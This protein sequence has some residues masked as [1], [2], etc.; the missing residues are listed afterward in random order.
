MFYQGKVMLRISWASGI[1][2]L[3][4]WGKEHH[5]VPISESSLLPVILAPTVSQS[6]RTT[7]RF[8][9]H[10]LVLLPLELTHAL[11]EDCLLISGD[12]LG[13]G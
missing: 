1:G 6:A 4:D 5:V 9:A 12:H 13:W 7:H 2:I 3:D 8:H 10:H 11:L